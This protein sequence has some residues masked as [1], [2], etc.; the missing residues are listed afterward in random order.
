[1]NSRESA[2]SK[3]D[4]PYVIRSKHRK[5]GKV[6]L[7]DSAETLEEARARIRPGYEAHVYLRGH[8]VYS[9]SYWGNG[10]WPGDNL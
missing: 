3:R 10:P 1:M 4:R 9:V 5:R 6:W 8:E 7:Y 2:S